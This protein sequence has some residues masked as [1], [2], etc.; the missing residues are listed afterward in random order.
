MDGCPSR[1]QAEAEPRKDFA[2]DIAAQNRNTKMEKSGGNNVNERDSLSPMC[3]PSGALCNPAEILAVMFPYRED[4][5]DP[6]RLVPVADMTPSGAKNDNST[7][8]PT[9]PIRRGRFLVWPVSLEGPYL[10][11]SAPSSPGF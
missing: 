9:S 8:P 2:M 10:T 4:E 3:D 6:P 1:T 11:T 7:T 5:D